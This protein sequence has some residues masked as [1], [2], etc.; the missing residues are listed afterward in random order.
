MAVR[1]LSS[2]IIAIIYMFEVNKEFMVIYLLR[3]PYRVAFLK[4]GAYCI[5][6]GQLFFGLKCSRAQLAIHHSIMMLRP[7]CC[8]KLF[9]KCWQILGNILPSDLWYH[10][11]SLTE[12]PL[13]CSILLGFSTF[14]NSC[15]LFSLKLEHLSD[16]DDD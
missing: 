10:K 4:D 5:S 8:L 1:S 9:T 16:I 6:Q 3:R 14:Y 7:R 11:V 2:K 12:F 15:V 13:S